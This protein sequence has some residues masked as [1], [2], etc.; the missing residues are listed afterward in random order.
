MLGAE[1]IKL[2]PT[3]HKEIQ[4][5]RD[6][7]YFKAFV[8]KDGTV[9]LGVPSRKP[10]PKTLKNFRSKIDHDGVWWN[11]EESYKQIEDYTQEAR[12]IVHSTIATS[13]NLRRIIR[14]QVTARLNRLEEKLAAIEARLTGQRNQS[15]Q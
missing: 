10:G 5:R 3:A 6:N 9:L 8:L 4:L 2:A 12:L 11:I 13:L 14:E 7:V 15:R 1:G